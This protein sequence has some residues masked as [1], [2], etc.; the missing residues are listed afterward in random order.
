M[1]LLK[2][3]RKNLYIVLI[4]FVSEKLNLCGDVKVYK[5]YLQKY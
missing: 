1:S 2:A 4:Y 5:K 3:I